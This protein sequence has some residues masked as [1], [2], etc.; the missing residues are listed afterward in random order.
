MKQ[1]S[2][3]SPWRR[4]LHTAA[5]LPLLL[6]CA[7]STAEDVVRIIVPVPP[8]GGLDATAR[9]LAMGLSSVTGASYIIENRPGAN[10]ALGA[11]LVARSPADGSTILYSGTAIV[12]N[13]WLQKLGPSPVTELHPLLYLSNNEYVLVAAATGTIRSV[14]DVQARAASPAGLSC[15][16]PPGPM[17]LACEQLKVRMRGSVIV[18]PYVGIA[19][20]VGALIGG[21][22]DAMFVNVDGIESLIKAGSVRAIA[23]SA[24]SAA[25]GVPLIGQAW[26]GLYLEGFTGFFVPAHT[27]AEKV[28]ELNEAMNRVLSQPAFRKFM[29]ETKQEIVGGTPQEFARKI[30]SAYERYGEVIRK[31]NLA[32]NVPSSI[33]NPQ[34]P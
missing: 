1:K 26:P 3:L 21:H 34:H 33:T 30:S 27:P 32:V 12:M 29:S 13:P 11:D 14:A 15:A 18:V 8:G 5:C 19:P 24:A 9:A 17:Q 25:A 10:T 31:A 22:V 7:T 2:V 28:R 20:A 4:V 16:A 23:A 6:A